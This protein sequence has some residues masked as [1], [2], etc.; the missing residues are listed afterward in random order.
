M[1]TAQANRIAELE[2]E[3]DQL[4]AQVA[5]LRYVLFSLSCVSFVLI[6]LLAI[7]FGYGF[8]PIKISTAPSGIVGLVDI[9]GNPIAAT[10]RTTPNT[11]SAN[12]DQLSQLVVAD[13]DN[14][15]SEKEYPI[16]PFALA[17]AVGFAIQGIAVLIIALRRIK[18]K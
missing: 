17:G 5:A 14:K 6:L 11:S 8:W 3:R 4:Q 9:C 12:S 2:A 15:N 13:F 10:T 1:S 18:G 7:S 16:S